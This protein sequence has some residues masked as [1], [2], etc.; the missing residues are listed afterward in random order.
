MSLTVDNCVYN[1][2]TLVSLTTLQSTVKSV[3][4]KMKEDTGPRCPDT[5]SDCFGCQQWQLIDRLEAA[6]YTA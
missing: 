6:I 5:D 1:N 4:D 2:E 3:V